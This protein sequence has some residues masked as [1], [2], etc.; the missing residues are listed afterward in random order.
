MRRCSGR[1]NSAIDQPA[2]VIFLEPL[3]QTLLAGAH[4]GVPD[5][6]PVVLVVPESFA[7]GDAG[8]L[9]A[10]PEQGPEHGRFAEV[11]L[12][13]LVS[14]R[15][16]FAEC[17]GK[18]SRKGMARGRAEFPERRGGDFFAEAGGHELAKQPVRLA[19]IHPRG[20]GQAP[21]VECPPG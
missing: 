2:P 16:R 5:K 13:A 15:C 10:G 21:E 12:L 7:C 1:W 4:G 17:L 3:E 20:R 19:G 14:L 8:A 6:A 18:R 9:A 11:D